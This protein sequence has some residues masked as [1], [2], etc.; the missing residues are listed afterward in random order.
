M[1][2]PVICCI[3]RFVNVSSMY[4]WLFFLLKV[5]EISSPF[6]FCAD[7]QIYTTV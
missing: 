7:S 5:P 4:G 1:A 6:P 3:A 2:K